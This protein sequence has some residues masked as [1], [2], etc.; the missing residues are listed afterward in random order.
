MDIVILEDLSSEHFVVVGSEC[1]SMSL[2]VLPANVGKSVEWYF[3]GA[4]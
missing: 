1:Y 2:L 4:S 3:I